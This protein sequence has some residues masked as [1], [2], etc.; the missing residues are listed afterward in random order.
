MS[1]AFFYAR[2][3]T[4][5]KPLKPA[6]APEL[7]FSVQGDYFPRHAMVYCETG[8]G[9]WV[10]DFDVLYELYIEQ[11]PIL[12]PAHIFIY[13]HL[14]SLARRGFGIRL[15]NYAATVM[16][17]H[18]QKL[19]DHLDRLQDARLLYRVCRVDTKGRPNDIVLQ[20]PLSRERWK[21]EGEAIL[22]RVRTQCT[23]L[24]RREMGRA[25][26]GDDY[27]FSQKKITRVFGDERLAEQFT[28]LVLDLL[29]QLNNK[30]WNGPEAKKLFEEQL[31]KGAERNQF[32]MDEPKFL[33]ALEIKRRYAPKLF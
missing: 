30:R 6:T 19:V 25:W 1:E 21:Q 8:L 5:F 29:F 31:M 32:F 9:G 11:N 26:P 27:K 16:H 33:A 23:K 14:L 10:K 15:K 20:T 22:E 18:H 28:I 17:W 24:E 7:F 13:R 3:R 4:E 2:K 12:E